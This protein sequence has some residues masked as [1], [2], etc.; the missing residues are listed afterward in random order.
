MSIKLFRSFFIAGVIA[1]LLLILFGKMLVP[2]EN[3]FG[4]VGAILIM[5]IYGTTASF[6]SQVPPNAIPFGIAAGTVFATEMVAEYVMLPKDN[7]VYGYVEFAAVFLIYLS[8]GALTSYRTKSIKS[9]IWSAVWAAMISSLI[10]VV[11]VLAVFYI[12]RGTPEQTK[13]FL[14]EGNYIDFLRSNEKNFNIWI[15]EDFMGAVFYH[16]LLGPFIAL[17]LG[18]IGGLVSKGMLKLP[19]PA[20]QKDAKV[21]RTAGRRRD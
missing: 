14:A 4:F 20:H 18:F 16:S 19:R 17:I 3:L 13:V 12:F 15:M 1:S 21:T 7:T 9:G 2:Q 5:M 10:W 11:V 6:L 8:A